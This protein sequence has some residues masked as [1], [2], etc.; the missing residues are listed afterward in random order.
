MMRPR[1]FLSVLASLAL[2]AACTGSAADVPRSDNHRSSRFPS[3]SVFVDCTS[4][5]SGRLDDRW[6]TH[7]QAVGPAYFLAATATPSSLGTSRHLRQAAFLK[8]LILV[9]AGQQVALRMD[10]R[11]DAALLYGPHTVPVGR[12]PRVEDGSAEVRF[13]ACEQNLTQ[14]AGGIVTRQSGAVELTVTTSRG[15]NRIRIG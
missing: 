5:V 15:V 7:A 8:V 10:P 3:R 4:A 11:A 13:R 9:E 2:S 1:R 12:S 14:F 6:R